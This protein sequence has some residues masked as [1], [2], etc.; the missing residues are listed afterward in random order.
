MKLTNARFEAI[1]KADRLFTAIKKEPQ[2][3]KLKQA[4]EVWELSVTVIEGKLK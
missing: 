3:Q 2:G 4:T 1:K